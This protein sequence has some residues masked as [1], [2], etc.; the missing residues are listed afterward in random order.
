LTA[1]RAAFDSWVDVQ[2]RWVYL[3]GILFGSSD[4][5]AQLPAEWSRFKSI[6]TEFVSLMRRIAGKPYAME[7]LNIE[8]LQRTLE[9]LGNLMGVIQRALGEYLTKQRSDFSRFYFLGDD[10]L[11]EIMGNSGEP[12]KVLAHVGKM[13]SGIAGARLV[14]GTLPEKV[15]ARLDAMVSKDGELVEFNEP[16]DIHDG[17][18][19]KDWLKSLEDR[20]HSTLSLL[21]GKAV[22]L[23][24]FS[25]CDMLDGGIKNDF[26]AWTTKFPAQ[27]RSGTADEC[28]KVK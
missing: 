4:I 25:D 14:T 20:M 17:T 8:N 3:E 19:V 10:D 2:R 18:N 7:V 12:G 22:D 23:D 11:L 26:V 21:L 15:R 9:R 1:L 24:V 16:I 28:Y 13:F 27:V 5:K 6:D